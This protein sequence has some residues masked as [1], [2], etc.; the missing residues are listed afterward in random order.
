MQFFGAGGFA[1][2]TRGGVAMRSWPLLLPT[3]A[4]S[5]FFSLRLLLLTH[6]GETP[7]AE[8]LFAPIY[9]NVN[10]DFQRFFVFL[11]PAFGHGR[12]GHP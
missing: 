8:N 7:E 3:F 6:F 11:W 9:F 12:L 4:L 1:C 2:V 5:F 10:N